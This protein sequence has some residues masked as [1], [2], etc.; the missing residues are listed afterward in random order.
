MT[1]LMAVKVLGLLAALG[2]FV[3]WQWRDL[4]RAGRRSALA[5]KVVLITGA[6]SGIGAAGARALQRAGAVPVLVD[7]DTAPLA[8]LAA[9]MDAEAAAAGRQ[10]TQAEGAGADQPAAR[11][12]LSVVADVTVPAQCAAAVAA[13]VA[14]HGRL[15]VVWA[16]AGVA[17]FGPL[18]HTDP[19]AWQR[20]IDVNV[21]GV[22]HTVRA[23]LPELLRQR[24]QVLVSASASSF[25]HPPLMSAYAA[26]KAAVEAMC[27]AWRIELAAHGV[28][29]SVLHASWVRTPLMDEGALHPAFTRLRATMPGLLNGEV[30]A[31]AAARTILEGL[32]GRRR[33]IWVPGW[34]VWL[35]V[36]RALLHTRAAERA[37]REAAPDLERLYLA[38][39][40][41]SGTAASSFGPRE[42]ARSQQRP[43]A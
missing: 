32:A 37:L 12:V 5:G 22:F 34:V 33:R 35:H 18:A 24:G 31:D 41:E 38:G 36:L 17:S 7:C 9:A 4:A 40:A 26:S 10:P 27:N 21:L 20:C 28:S 13:A 14:R 29:V 11:G 39:L 1:W 6:A 30:S 19:Q 8:A 23:A 42:L 3:V 16:N 2:L 25:A 43:P 15:D